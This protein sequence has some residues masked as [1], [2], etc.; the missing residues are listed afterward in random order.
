MLVINSASSLE[1]HR[2]ESFQFMN[3]RPVDGFVRK[4]VARTAKDIGLSA[5]NKMEVV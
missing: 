1:C 2:T 3:G 5:N 4:V